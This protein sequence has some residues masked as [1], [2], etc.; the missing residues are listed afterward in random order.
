MLFFDGSSFNYQMLTVLSY[1]LLYSLKVVCINMKALSNTII[2][3]VSLFVEPN[4]LLVDAAMKLVLDV[5]PDVS[6]DERREALLRASRHALMRGVT[7]VV[8]VGSYFPGMSE[9]QPWQD[10]SGA[11]IIFCL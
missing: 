10:F 9:N 8:D 4:G 1:N 7:T 5:I 2:L 3:L 11:F 6:V